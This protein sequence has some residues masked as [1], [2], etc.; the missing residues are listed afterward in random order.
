MPSSYFVYM[1][2]CADGALYIGKTEDLDE[3]L[4]RHNEGAAC[5]FTR[6]RHPV[7]LAWSEEHSRFETAVARERQ[8]KGWTRAKKEALVAGNFD[9]L[10]DLS[11]S[12]SSLNRASGSAPGD[13]LPPRALPRPESLRPGKRVV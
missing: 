10:R 13:T 7:S 8:I 9:H 3:R 4:R 2:C 5:E 11:R 1:L 6:L 12:R